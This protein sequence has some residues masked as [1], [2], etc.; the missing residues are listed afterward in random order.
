MAHNVPPLAEG[1]RLSDGLQQAAVSPRR[2]FSFPGSFEFKPR[3]VNSG[4]PLERFSHSPSIPVDMNQECQ[5][6]RQEGEDI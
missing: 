2:S 5:G 3:L 1:R 4:S 6:R